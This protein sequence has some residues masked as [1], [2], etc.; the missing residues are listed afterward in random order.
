MA[1]KGQSVPKDLE[2]AILEKNQIRYTGFIAQEVE[3]AAEQTGF[4]FSGVG[5]P[6]SISNIQHLTSN[7]YGL[8]YAEFVVPLVKTTQELSKKVATLEKEN[9]ALLEEYNTQ[10]QLLTE[11]EAAAKNILL[12]LEVLENNQ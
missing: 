4:D 8:R 5:K 9:T 2:N 10:Q 1:H 12:R 7:I 6:K 3:Q 11:Y